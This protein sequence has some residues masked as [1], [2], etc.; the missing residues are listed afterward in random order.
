[1]DPSAGD[2]AAGRR[3]ALLRLGLYGMVL[4]AIFT[5]AL[6]TGSIPSADEARD[7][8]DG[9]GPFAALAYIPLFVLANFVVAWAILAGAGGLLFGTAIGWPLALAGV[10]LAGL[11]QMATARRLA[12]D[13]AGRLLPQRV[14]GL[15]AFLQHN[16]T[17]AVMESRIVPFLPYGVINYAAGL[18]RLGYREMAMGT[19]IGAAPKVFAYVALGGSISNL[20]ATEV[21]VAIGLLVVLGIIG[22]VVVRRRISESASA[23]V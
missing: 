21:K 19:L 14:R 22:I 1:M 4:G 15:E 12:K 6:L 23:P 17:V 13:H 2:H 20:R 5:V 11:A 18:T 9:L 16:G 3:A 7:F 8:G 10:T